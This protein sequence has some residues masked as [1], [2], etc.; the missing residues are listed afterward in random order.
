[1]LT[2]IHVEVAIN[3]KAAK[4]PLRIYDAATNAFGVVVAGQ[5]VPVVATGPKSVRLVAKGVGRA[6]DACRNAKLADLGIARAEPKAL[7]TTQ[8]AMI[9]GKLTPE[10]AAQM[11]AMLS[12]YLEGK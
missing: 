3:G 8:A 12:S 1:M 6:K 5:C 7:A 11:I 9:T 2:T 4:R 10:I